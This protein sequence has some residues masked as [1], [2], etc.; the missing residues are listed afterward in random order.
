MIG[1]Y[2][3]AFYGSQY[4]SMAPL[5]EHYGV[6]LWMPEVG[7]RELARRL[8]TVR[9]ELKVLFMSGYADDA[10]VQ[11]GV[12]EPGAAYLQKPFTPDALAGKI[13]ELLDGE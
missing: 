4:A 3:W 12:L 7:G 2:E 10:I 9:R 13:R 1:E 8:K 11:Q 5:F 6:S